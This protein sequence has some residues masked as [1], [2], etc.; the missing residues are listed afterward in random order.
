MNRRHYLPN[1]RTRLFGIVGQPLEHSL[2][3]EIHT[4]VLRRL[5]QNLLYVP[6][7]VSPQRLPVFLR[8]A[9]EWGVRGLNV[10]YPYKDLAYRS[11]RPAD[12]ETRRTRMVNTLTYDRAGDSGPAGEGT[13]GAGVLSWMQSAGAGEAALGVLGF[14]ATARSLIHRAWQ[15]G[16]SIRF[17]V[18][19]RPAQVR[20]RLG[21]WRRDAERRSGARLRG[22]TPAVLDW[23]ELSRGSKGETAHLRRLA[24]EYA[25]ARSLIIVSTLPPD[26]SVPVRLVRALGEASAWL[27]MNYGPRA[28]LAARLE[29]EGLWYADGLGPLLHQAALSMSRWLG[30]PIEP[31][32]FQWAAGVSA[33]RVSF[34]RRRGVS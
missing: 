17:V 2:S 12:A 31:D 28:R 9:G 6:F 25:R 18:T 27:D 1:G 24:D 34:Q 20:G 29:N 22:E 10:T 30:R 7:E 23:R 32:L 8:R 3:P 11:A 4:A 33:R 13:D 21:A 14:G 16:R 5:E 15:D 26:A 19:R